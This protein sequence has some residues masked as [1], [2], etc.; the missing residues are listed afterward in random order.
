MTTA[1]ST[2]SHQ[3][4]LCTELSLHNPSSPLLMNTS[5]TVHWGLRIRSFSDNSSFNEIS[6]MST[7]QY[8]DMRLNFTTEEGARTAEKR[9]HL[10]RTSP[11]IMKHR[12]LWS[13]TATHQNISSSWRYRTCKM[14]LEI[15]LTSITPAFIS[16]WIINYLQCM[17]TD[18]LG[19]AQGKRDMDYG[20][21]D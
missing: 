18:W 1:Y 17:Q 9:D 20:G 8:R 7:W 6:W 16:R 21:L 19:L 10:M 14:L 11:K 13:T 2:I 15:I 5:C 12:K 3:R 4:F